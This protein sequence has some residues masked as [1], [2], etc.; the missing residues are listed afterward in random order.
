M[1]TRKITADLDERRHADSQ[2]AFERRI[3]HLV[4]GLGALRH[5]RSLGHRQFDDLG[6]FERN[7]VAL[8]RQRHN[9]RVGLEVLDGIPEQF[10]GNLTG[11]TSRCP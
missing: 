6:Q 10:T 4:R 3:F 8:V 5:R 2:A 11:R 7:D 9:Q 1:F